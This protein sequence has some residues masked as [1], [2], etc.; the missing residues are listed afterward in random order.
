[1]KGEKD[2]CAEC[3]ELR[4]KVRDLE[5]QRAVAWR[6]VACLERILADIGTR[7]DALAEVLSQELQG[8]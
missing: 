5:H 7:A 8:D 2:R 4:T 1:M 3:D 6:R